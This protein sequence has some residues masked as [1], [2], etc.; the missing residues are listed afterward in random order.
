MIVRIQSL[1]LQMSD[2]VYLPSRIVE[3]AYGKVEGRRLINE[4]DRQVD[5]FQ[6]KLLY[7]SLMG[8]NAFEFLS[9][10]V[11]LSP[12]LPLENFDSK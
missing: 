3:T 9:F 2:A 4:G 6:V 12:L 8:E 7:L 1:L 5:A 10:R 11:F